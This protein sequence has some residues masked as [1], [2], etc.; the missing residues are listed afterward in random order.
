MEAKQILNA[1]LLDIIF[2]DRNKEYGAYDLRATY[3]GRV[4]KSLLVMFVLIGLVFT[5]LALSKSLTPKAPGGFETLVVNLTDITIPDEKKPEE[6]PKEK[7]KQ[8]TP[9]VKTRAFVPPVIVPDVQVKNLIP[10]IADL[11]GSQIG[12]R[13]IEGSDHGGIVDTTTK[14]NG[15][16]TA[17]VTQAPEPDRIEHTV[18][19]PASC[20][21]NWAKFLLANLRG[22]V[23][24]D[25]GAPAGRY[26]VLIQFVVDREGNVS[27]IKP[28]TDHGYGMETEAMRVLKKAKGWKPGIQNGIEVKSYHRQPITFEVITE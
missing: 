12:T 14:S 5:G 25:N 24:V 7:P 6:L 22:E 21:C 19:I 1:S 9:P 20:D 3:T 2:D 15:T 10:E 16:G 23:P 17:N 8:A 27:D 18:D 4:V 28:L 11:R 13:D 26:T